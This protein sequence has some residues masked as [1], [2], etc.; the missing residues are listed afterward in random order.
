MKQSYFGGGRT[1]FGGRKQ[2]DE[3]KDS[4][5]DD[6][7]ALTLNFDRTKVASGQNGQE[8]LVLIWDALTGKGLKKKRLPKGCR[9]VTALGFSKDDKY[10]CAGD[11]AEKIAVHVFEVEGGVKPICNVQINQKIAH[12]AWSPADDTKFVCVGKDHIA[13]CTVAGGKIEKKMG[14]AKGGNPVSQCAASWLA[15][16]SHCI[17]ASADGNVLQWKDG[18]IVKEYPV[19]KGV[20]TSVACRTDEK[21]GGEVVLAGCSSKSL[22]VFKMEGGELKQQW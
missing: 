2:G 1:D 8:P 16:G 6:I 3:S 5:S 13:F 14:S 9:L 19:G 21:A 11:A 4:H 12:L 10:L 17:T 7:T 18:A 15:D 20:V 22:H